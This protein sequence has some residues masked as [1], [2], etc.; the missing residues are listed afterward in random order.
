MDEIPN[1][2]KQGDFN[3][4]VYSFNGKNNPENFISFIGSLGDFL[5]KKNKRWLYKTKRSKKKKLKNN[6]NQILMK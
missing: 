2:S 1:L 3:N 4:L 5:K 6:S